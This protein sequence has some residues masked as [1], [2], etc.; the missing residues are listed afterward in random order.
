MHALL[1]LYFKFWRCF[2]KNLEDRVTRSFISCCFIRFLHQ[3]ISFSQIF[4]TSF[5]RFRTSFNFIQKNILVLNFPFL[6]DL[7]KHSPLPTLNSQNP[8]SVTKVFCQCFL[9]GHLWLPTMSTNI[10]KVPQVTL[11]GFAETVYQ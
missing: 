6:T 8:L 3:Q 9:V 10:L 2:Y 1:T 4:R 11:S 5:N 7:L